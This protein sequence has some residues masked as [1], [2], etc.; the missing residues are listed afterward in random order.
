M[1]PSRFV[2]LTGA[3][4]TKNFRGYLG[5]EMWSA[6]FSQPIVAE[7]PQ[8]RSEMLNRMDFEQSYYHV[9]KGG[10]HSAAEKQLLGKAVEKAYQEMHAMIHGMG[11]HDKAILKFVLRNIVALFAGSGDERGFVFT[12]SQD[13]LF[14]TFYRE[15]DPV[16]GKHRL[17]IPM[18]ET[19]PWVFSD[20]APSFLRQGDWVTV[21]DEEKVK[22]LLSEFWDSHPENK[23]SYIKLHGS[24]GWRSA[25]GSNTMV[26]GGEKEQ[27][28]SAEPLLEA[29]F[30]IF[31]QVLRGPNCKLLIIGY[32][33]KDPHINQRIVQAV[34]NHGLKVFIISPMQPG[35]FCFELGDDR[36]HPVNM[37]W[38]SGLHGYFR[39][40]LQD[41][42]DMD[43]LKLSP[44]GEVFLQKINLSGSFNR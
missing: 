2:L 40:V 8:L 29:Y 16:L 4:F 22:V 28:I 39:G 33:F 19:Q 1:K 25:D 9:M 32:G 10:K 30:E 12:L 17:C 37:I 18:L 23:F 7:S 5:G 41:L 20:K 35:K 3:G 43:K 15:S 26:I 13:L 31:D 36:E 38:N 34:R 6:I 11:R 21:S 14:E 24:Y 27:R 42:L 44:D